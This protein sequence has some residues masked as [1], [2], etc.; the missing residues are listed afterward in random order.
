[1]KKL[2]TKQFIEQVIKKLGY[3]LISIWE[4]DYKK[5]LI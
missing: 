3:N 1:M 5:E 2:T 4:N